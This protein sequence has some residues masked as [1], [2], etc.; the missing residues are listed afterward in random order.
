MN[1]RPLKNDRILVS[2]FQILEEKMRNPYGCLSTTTP[3]KGRVWCS[4]KVYYA[5]LKLMEPTLVISSDEFLSAIR[6]GNL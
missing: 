3:R 1:L 6:H 2:N 4:S 5:L